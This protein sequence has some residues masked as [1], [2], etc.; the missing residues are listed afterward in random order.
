MIFFNWNVRNYLKER[1]SQLDSTLSSMQDISQSVSKD[2][3]KK[4]AKKKATSNDTHE[5]NILIMIIIIF[6]ACHFPR[7]ILKFSDGFPRHIGIEI[8]ETCERVLLIV[9]ASATPFI[10]LSKNKRFRG[11][12]M[13]TLRCKSVISNQTK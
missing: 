4:N 7:C 3:G 6:I 5:T 9:Y 13:D 10:Y 2:D 8:L 1:R 11:Q 12:L